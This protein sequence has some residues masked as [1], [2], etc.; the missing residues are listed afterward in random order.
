MMIASNSGCRTRAD[1]DDS[2]TPDL[3]KEWKQ[4]EKRSII[5]KLVLL[6]KKPSS[7][8]AI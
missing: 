3:Y 5:R 8:D 1:T 6:P 2:I 4:Y 7:N